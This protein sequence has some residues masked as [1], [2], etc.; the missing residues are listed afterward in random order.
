MTAEQD[1]V[2]INDDNTG[3]HKIPRILVL[4]VDNAKEGG[5]GRETLRCQ[6]QG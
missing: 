4:P 5:A 6:A 2:S 3:R 1:V